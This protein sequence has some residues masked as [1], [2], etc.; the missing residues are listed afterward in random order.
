[1]EKILKKKV[2]DFMVKKVVSVEENE[3]IKKVFKLMDKAGILGV[4]VVDDKKHV[5]GI[6]TETDLIEHFTTLPTP[7]FVNLL[8]GIIYLDNVKEY[9]AH[10]KDHCAEIVKDLMSKSVIT[11]KES[12]TLQEV[13]DL[14]S[15]QRKIRFPVVNRKGELVGIITRSDIIHQLA[16]VKRI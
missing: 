8:G 5:V 4:P 11:I 10:L 16:K 2:K 7:S 9:N 13:V 6:I 1:M 3:P 12:T 15:D 14:M